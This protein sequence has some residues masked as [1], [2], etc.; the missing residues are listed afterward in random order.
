MAAC[1]LLAILVLLGVFLPTFTRAIV[2]QIL[3]LAVLLVLLLWLAAFLLRD[4]PR[5]SSG[6]LRRRKAAD[7][8]WK[9][10]SRHPR[11]RRRRPVR[12]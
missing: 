10:S 6:M 5:L 11:S 4:L 12:S 9:P 7:G 3:L 2:N 8:V 1:V